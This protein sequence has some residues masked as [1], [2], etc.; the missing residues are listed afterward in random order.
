MSQEKIKC[1]VWDLDNTLWHGTL[2]EG[3][4]LILRNG[5]VET[6]RELDRRGILQSIASRN[7]HEHAMGRLQAL[8]LAEYFLYPQIGWGA[9]SASIRA[10][11]SALN[12]GLDSFA[13][14]DD[15]PYERAEVAN[16]L[17]QVRCIDAA[18]L[19]GLT[20][21]PAM[22]PRFITEDSARRREMYRGDQQRQALEAAHSGPRET[23]LRSLGMELTIAPARE[24]DLRRAE[25]LTLR[26]H[27]LNTTGYAYSYDE[28]LGLSR[29]PRHLLLVASL[30]DRFGS[31]GKI[32]L[33]LVEQGAEAWTIKLLLMSCRVMSHG[34]GGV[35]ISHLREAAQGAGAALRAEFIH[36]DR[37]RMMFMT[38]RF[39]GFRECVEPSAA[40]GAVLLEADLSEPYPFP[41]YLR[42]RI[43]ACAC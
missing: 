32:G 24:P 9:K 17:P 41:D 21:M 28:L 18:E 11:A 34:V 40:D 22:R 42:V 13:F 14:I 36:T 20:A 27:Q 7:E 37:N 2:L 23:F 31:Y 6:I 3:D 43:E 38:Y 12:I 1:L 33:T 5:A 39:A 26:T 16:A 19:D 15:Q 8:G 35:M 30:T 10:I 29:S 4:D 25:E